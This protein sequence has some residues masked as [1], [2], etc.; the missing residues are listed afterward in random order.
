M[1]AIP[2]FSLLLLGMACAG[3]AR[4]GRVA[5]N[6]YVPTRCI[7]KVSW[8]RP[9]ATL[10]EHVIKCDGV[11]VTTRCVAPAD[12]DGRIKDRDSPAH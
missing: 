9:C 2:W 6:F 3:C 5:V 11:M 10:S 1:K 8:T 4:P 7:Q 12:K